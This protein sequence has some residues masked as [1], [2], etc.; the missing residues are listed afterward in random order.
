M[1]FFSLLLVQIFITLKTEPRRSANVV[2][3]IQTTFYSN[4]QEAAVVEIFI[5]RDRKIKSL[6]FRFK[7]TLVNMW[8]ISLI[9]YM[10]IK[11]SEVFFFYFSGVCKRM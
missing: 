10:A 7:A 6:N 11:V 1:T 9:S 4:P 8:N 2:V 5:K 3:G